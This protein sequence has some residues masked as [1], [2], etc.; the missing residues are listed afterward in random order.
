MTLPA[1]RDLAYA[2]GSQVSSANLNNIQDCIIRS[3]GDVWLTVP[4]IGVVSADVTAPIQIDPGFVRPATSTATIWFCPISIP[5]GATIKE[6]VARADRGGAGTI[7]VA[8]RR[9]HSSGSSTTLH[10]FTIN[11]GTGWATVSQ[12]L[13]APV[14][15]GLDGYVF[16][17]CEADNTANHVGALRIRYELGVPV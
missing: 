17:R 9:H 15:V 11:S 5:S 2:S 4:P 8:L 12:V 6:V 1:S 13:G 7:S 3:S 16:F 14:Q 10:I